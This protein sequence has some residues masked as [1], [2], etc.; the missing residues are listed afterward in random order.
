MDNDVLFIT[1]AT[2]KM[3]FVQLQSAS[4]KSRSCHSIVT[5]LATAAF[6][7]TN[8]AWT[9]PF[10]LSSPSS[11]KKTTLEL[12]LALNIYNTFNPPSSIHSN[13]RT[14]QSTNQQNPLPDRSRETIQSTEADTS[15][16]PSHTQSAGYS[17]SSTEWKPSLDR[18]QSWSNEDRKHQMQGKLMQP[19][20]GQEEGFTET[21][22]S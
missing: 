2:P 14:M 4:K 12:K 1:T 7:C 11:I 16:E 15:I 22:G 3:S 20:E 6:K 10:I 17:T 9:R 18:R 21:L 5:T 19:G 8:P 13:Q